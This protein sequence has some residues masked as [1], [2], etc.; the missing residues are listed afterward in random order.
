MIIHISLNINILLLYFMI[1]FTD[2]DCD[3][4]PKL[5]EKKRRI[6]SPK[7]VP[8]P[9]TNE[10]PFEQLPKKERQKPKDKIVCITNYEIMFKNVYKFAIGAMEIA[11][12]TMDLTT[13]EGEFLV[14]GIR[15]EN[16][17]TTKVFQEELKVLLTQTPEDKFVSK[18]EE[19]KRS[20]MFM[21]AIL[22][23]TTE[24]LVSQSLKFYSISA[25]FN[26]L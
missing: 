23:T 3:T 7:K 10:E 26:I 16:Q 2:S 6:K 1:K 24:I 21:E 13:N 11:L 19:I 22:R 5:K 17:G 14:W 15:L 4:P 12:H 18:S 9:I 20:R 8:G 25:Y